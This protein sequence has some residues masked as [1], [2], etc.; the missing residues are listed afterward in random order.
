MQINLLHSGLPRSPVE[1]LFLPACGHQPH[2][3]Q[4]PLV[5]EAAAAFLARS[6]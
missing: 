6:M 4:R 5:L 3:E 1:T 2:L